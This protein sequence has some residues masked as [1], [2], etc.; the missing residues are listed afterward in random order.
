MFKTATLPLHRS[1]LNAPITCSNCG[2]PMTATGVNYVCATNAAHGPSR[3]P[4]T[5][6]EAGTLIVQIATLVLKRVMN[7]S[8]V[9]LLTADVQQATSE[10]LRTQEERLQQS[11]SAIEELN[12][13]KEQILEPVEQQLATYQDVAEAIHR[14]NATKMGLAYE[15]QIAQEEIDKLDFMGDTLGLTDDARDIATHLKDADPE[16]TAKLLDIFVQEVR[17]GPGTAEIIYTHPLP[18]EQ[19]HPKVLSDHI[20]L[21]T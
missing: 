11:E 13:L 10:M 3:C 21:P 17:V 4:T 9:E 16:E 5:P 18:D 1:T 14:L 7:E 15:S 12:A 20:A 2:T 6:V 19:N 8:T